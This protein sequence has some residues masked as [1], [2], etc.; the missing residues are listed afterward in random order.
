MD[1]GLSWSWIWNF[2]FEDFIEILFSTLVAFFLI[3]FH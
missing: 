3:L 1:E 2:F